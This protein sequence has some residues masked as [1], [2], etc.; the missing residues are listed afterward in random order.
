MDFVLVN[1]YLYMKIYKEQELSPK[2]K[3]KL[4]RKE[5][6]ENLID[7]FINIDWAKMVHDY[8]K[9]Q[10]KGKEE[11]WITDCSDGNGEILVKKN[12]LKMKLIT[13]FIRRY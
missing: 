9:N 11:N 13:I 1:S 5:F 4:D 7:S 12:Y 2:P 3:K 8:E 6:M 10:L